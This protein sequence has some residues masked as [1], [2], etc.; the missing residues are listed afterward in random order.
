MIKAYLVFIAIFASMAY[1]I[2]CTHEG[3]ARRVL[4]MDGI[5]DVQM[6]G[7]KFFSC[8]KGDWYHTGFKGKRNGREIEGVVCSGLIFKSSTIRY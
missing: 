7:Y 3:E 8:S 6:T 4:A 5:E 2:G 1:M